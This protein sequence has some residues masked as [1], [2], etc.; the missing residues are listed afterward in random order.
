M[1]GSQATVIITK[2]L[3]KLLEILDRIRRE[4]LER[5][6]RKREMGLKKKSTLWKDKR[7]IGLA[8]SFKKDLTKRELKV[9]KQLREKK[10]DLDLYKL[11]MQAKLEDLN[12]QVKKAE[13]ALEVAEKNFAKGVTTE[14]NFAE[15]QANI[16]SK[17]EAKRNFEIEVNKVLL[18][19]DR[20]YKELKAVH[21][22]ILEDL[23]TCD[24]AIN[25][26]S[27]KFNKHATESLRT[28][29][30]DVVERETTNIEPKESAPALEDK[31][32]DISINNDII[33][34]PDTNIDIKDE[35]DRNNA[36]IQ[37][38]LEQQRR[39]SLN[40]QRTLRRDNIER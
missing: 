21:D 33:D 27:S 13:K 5:S 14:P 11:E 37:D 18:K 3:I 20:D 34:G 26:F 1:E 39:K 29:F 32:I 19:K 2:L 7:Q 4:Y 10:Y 30:K 15:L 23:K 16:N 40:Q 36:A 9:D 6:L 12:V 22:H 28:D 38:Y 17:L 35:L 8:K 25:G 24:R 31:H